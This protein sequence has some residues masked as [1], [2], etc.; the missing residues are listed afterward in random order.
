[1]ILVDT[2]VWVDHLRVGEPT[3]AQ[4]LEDGRA[5]GHPWVAGELALGHLSNRTEIL[6][7]VAGLPQSA[8]ATTQEVMTLIDRR[9]LFGRGIG[10]VDAQLLAATLL[11]PPALLWTLDRKLADAAVAVGCAFGPGAEGRA[12]PGSGQP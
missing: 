9:E 10:Y 6:G 5:L 1:M 11:T 7:L 2:A 3:L 4:L 12:S 8:V